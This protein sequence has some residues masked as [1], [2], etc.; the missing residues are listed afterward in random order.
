M[1]LLDVRE[2]SDNVL[3]KTNL[4][5]LGDGRESMLY[6]SDSD[7]VI[8]K[9]FEWISNNKMDGFGLQRFVCELY[10]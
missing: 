8:E 6:A 5:N 9:H 7:E 1:P 3:Q 10:D 2:F 4:G